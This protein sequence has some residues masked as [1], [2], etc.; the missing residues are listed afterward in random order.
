MDK[1]Q[2][3]THNGRVRVAERAL[4]LHMAFGWLDGKHRQ[5]DNDKR[6]KRGPAYLLQV[7][8]GQAVIQSVATVQCSNSFLPH[9]GLCHRAKNHIGAEGYVNY[10]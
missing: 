8:L 7:L 2:A 1:R 9:V 10:F 3:S 4:N 5:A 6:Q